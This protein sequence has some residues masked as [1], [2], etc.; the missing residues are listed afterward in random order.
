M[1]RSA[2]ALIALCLSAIL[3]LAGCEVVFPEQ[4]GGKGSEGF[5]STA[6]SQ[7][8][9]GISEEGEAD[10]SAPQVESSRAEES[11]SQGSE[12]SKVPSQGQSSVPAPVPPQEQQVDD[13]KERTCTISISVATVLSN[14]DKANA[15]TKAALEK[16]PNGVI[17][18]NVQV[19]FKEGQSV[20]DVLKQVTQYNRMQLGSVGNSL[21]NSQYINSIENFKEFG[22]GD[23]SGWMYKVNGLF[24]N[25]GCSQY[26]VKDGDVI[27]WVYT[28]DL[29][30]DIGGSVRQQ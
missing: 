1:K 29:G 28:C 8:E 30:R 24:P 4:G 12:A 5:T 18:Q 13:Q 27:E 15:T 16:Y 26:I 6:S 20:F 9:A 17:L 19:T 25:Y 3:I 23:L 22:V 21:Y 11:A 2:M 14:V 7:V 10:S